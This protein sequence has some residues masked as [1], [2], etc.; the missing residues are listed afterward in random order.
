MSDDNSKDQFQ[1]V[2]KPDDTFDNWDLAGAWRMLEA[3][4]KE[5]LIRRAWAEGYKAGGEEEARRRM[6]E[7][8]PELNPVEPE[9]AS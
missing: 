5:R 7:K 1:E 3:Q 9:G 4:R 8:Y 6:E 2:E